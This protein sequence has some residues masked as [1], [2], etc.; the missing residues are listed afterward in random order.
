[1]N[2]EYCRV[3]NAVVPILSH[4]CD[5]A[6]L[7]SISVLLLQVISLSKQFKLPL[8]SPFVFGICSRNLSVASETCV[9][10]GHASPRVKFYLAQHFSAR[11][12]T[13]FSST[14]PPAV[15][16]PKNA[17]SPLHSMILLSPT[18]RRRCHGMR[19][20]FLPVCGGRP[21]L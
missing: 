10:L 20:V 7:S 14:V 2:N 5:R 9:L 11:R 6:P 8:P 12:L 1:M 19:R 18:F 4:Q 21:N 13:K 15:A 17:I 16:G 3:L